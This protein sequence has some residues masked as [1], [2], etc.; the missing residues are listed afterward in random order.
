ML[1]IASIRII[2]N[3]PDKQNVL[4]NVTTTP[5]GFYR[6]AKFRIESQITL[7][8]VII[9][10][11]VVTSGY[12]AWKSLSN[13]V[14]SIHEEALPDNKLFLI[15]DV[16][17][18]LSAIENNARLFVLTDNRNSLE[19]YD[20]LQTNITG[21]L[22]AL[23]TITLPESDERTLVDSF[24]LMAVSKVKLWNDVLNLHQKSKDN[25]NEFSEIYNR[26]EEQKFDTITTTTEK[27]GLL[28]RIFGKKKV[29]T[30]TT[31]VESEFEKDE[32]RDQIEE[33]QNEISERDE[34]INLLESNLIAQ[35]L[36]I[37]NKINRLISKAEQNEKQSL[38][39]KTNEADR[40]AT[41]TFK[42]LAG[43][44]IM[45]VVLLL[46]VV[47]MLY[48]YLNKRRKYERGLQK[49]RQEAENL[50]QA[51]EQFAANVSH[52]MRT[53]V[54]AIFGL[55]E[56]LLRRKNNQNLDEQISV[57]AQSA[58]HLNQIIND[59]LDFSKIQAG[60]IRFDA[61]HFSPEQVFREIHSLQK[62]SAMQKGIELN[63]HLSSKMP[64]A[65]IGD[66]LRLKQI[67][68]NIA[69][70]AIKFTGQGK[71]EIRADV[72][73]KKDDRYNIRL[74][75]SDTGIGISKE[76]LKIIFDEFVQAENQ[77]GKKYRGTGLGLSI[78]KKLVELQGGTIT[79]ES[80]PGNGT[81]V[82]VVIPYQEGDPEKIEKTRTGTTE[83]PDYFRQIR[84]LLAD[85]E[86]FNRF[87]FKA[88]FDKWNI[89]YSEATN[90]E[91]AVE[92]ALNDDFD[93][94]MM[95]VR[96]PK[97]NGLEATAEILQH[98]P[99][100]KIIAITATNDKAEM[101][102]CTDA[103]MSGFL[104]KP[105]SEEQLF[106]VI[107]STA[108]KETDAKTENE[109]ENYLSEMERMAA[110]DEVF[111]KEMI[112]LF[113]Q[114]TENGVAKIAAGIKEKNWQEVSEKAHKIAPQCRQIG[115]KQLYSNIKELEKSAEAQPVDEEKI[116]RLFAAVDKKI[117]DINRFF[118]NYLQRQ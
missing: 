93:I 31:I 46:L 5:T 89:H 81:E 71:V 91:E 60:R 75:I 68:L 103:G 77:D 24:R 73:E 22:Q 104:P 45:A 74:R 18:D 95:D 109:P 23:Y 63:L 11:A 58:S 59:T 118:S 29:V 61:V 57:L 52:E 37:T 48:K 19:S 47:F 84:V 78:V 117:K 40:L 39:K 76:D 20:S 4:S 88:I 82:I 13:I 113:I 38:I 114:S 41:L 12:F 101:K 97:K 17:N 28:R 106:A 92:M 79:I 87:L 116:N 83:V 96:M 30:D 108:N 43:F 15:K 99:S 107:H 70:N 100:A 110:G 98:K 50:A 53:P 42:R 6:M 1:L 36:V 80:E 112:L 102:R 56:Q 90:G 85:D 21:K 64:P 111:L 94:V 105:F 32:L 49:A 86:E 69:G 2:Q 10:A 26:L 8:A 27:K 9:A 35:N 3:K 25:E 14:S 115:N 33:V 54:N 7:L 72:K 66:P 62:F 16:A 44:S 55:A 67:L 51:K 34:Q 65:V